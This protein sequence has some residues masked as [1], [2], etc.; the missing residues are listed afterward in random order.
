MSWPRF[1]IVARQIREEFHFIVPVLIVTLTLAAAL[2]L[3]TLA[4]SLAFALSLSGLFLSA[5]CR[6]AT[7]LRRAAL[8]SSLPRSLLVVARADWQWRLA[9]RTHRPIALHADPAQERVQL[10]V[11]STDLFYRRLP[12]LLRLL[13]QRPDALI[14]RRHLVSYAADSLLHP[15]Q[16]VGLGLERLL[17]ANSKV[18]GCSC[19]AARENQC[20]KGEKAGAGEARPSRRGRLLRGWRWH[21]G[22]GTRRSATR[23]KPARGA[24]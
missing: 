10:C 15:V 23:P 1:L 19:A 20:R 16:P 4:P 13:D 2:P 11:V 22:H 21:G 8:L 14:S 3:A 12:N 18:A 7:T 9:F 6:L 5:F 24:G 17:C